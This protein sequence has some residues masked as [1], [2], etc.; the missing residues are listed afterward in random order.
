MQRLRC[1]HESDCVLRVRRRYAAVDVVVE[2]SV[3]GDAEYGPPHC[4]WASM[5][6][7][8]TDW[9]RSSAK[10]VCPDSVSRTTRSSWIGLACSVSPMA[11]HYSTLGPH[12]VG[13]CWP[14]LIVDSMR[15]ASTQMSTWPS[16]PMRMGST[17]GVA[18]FRIL[19]TRTRALTQ[20]ASTMCWSTSST[21]ARLW[22]PATGICDPAGC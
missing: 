10:L 1:R 6:P 9:T 8:D 13:S 19:S 22:L 15:L 17:S 14:L 3:P 12:T 16:V 2:F 4:T 20:S 18:T 7:S 11:G 5:V 21:Y